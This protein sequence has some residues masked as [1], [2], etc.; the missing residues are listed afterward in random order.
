VVTI[1]LVDVSALDLEA[2]ETLGA[3]AS[4]V[5]RVAVVWIAGQGLGMQHELAGRRAVVGGDDRP[6]G[7]SL[8]SSPS[9]LLFQSSERSYIMY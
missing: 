4:V 3:L 7:P 2:G 1:S 9:A 5:Q 6:A 8:L